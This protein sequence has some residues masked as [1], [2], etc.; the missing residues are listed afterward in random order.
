MR[1]RRD[2]QSGEI[3]HSRRS[4]AHSTVQPIIYPEVWP[5]D[6]LMYPLTVAFKDYKR[7]ISAA[8][9]DDDELNVYTTLA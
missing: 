7:A 9:V 2:R 6:Q 3:R 5:R 4:P 1:R 8:T